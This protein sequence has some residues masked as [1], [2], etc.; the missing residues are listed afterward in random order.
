MKQHLVANIEGL[1]VFLFVCACFFFLFQSFF[2]FFFLFQSVFYKSLT[3]VECLL[4]CKWLSNFP[5]VSVRKK[6]CFPLE[7]S[8]PGH[9]LTENRGRKKFFKTSP[10]N[11]PTWGSWCS[12]VNQFCIMGWNTGNMLWFPSNLL[13]ESW[14]SGPSSTQILCAL[15]LWIEWSKNKLPRWYWQTRGENFRRKQPWRSKSGFR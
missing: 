15:E 7:T 1:W 8:Q 12:P 13:A 5:L 10:E 9:C 6:F 14:G 3:A 11:L 2:L 4:P